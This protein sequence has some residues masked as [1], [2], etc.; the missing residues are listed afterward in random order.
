[1]PS[2]LYY[3]APRFFFLRNILFP[4]TKG[5]EKAENQPKVWLKRCISCIKPDSQCSENQACCRDNSLSCVA[6]GTIYWVLIWGSWALENQGKFFFFC[7]PYLHL[8][9]FPEPGIQ[10][11]LKCTHETKCLSDEFWFG[12]LVHLQPQPHFHLPDYF[13]TPI[14]PKYHFIWGRRDCISGRA[15]AFTKTI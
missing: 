7:L 12:Y 14:V 2:P 10:C 15:F 9:R 13:I 4:L 11:V 6:L 3:P 5:K 1:M 8:E